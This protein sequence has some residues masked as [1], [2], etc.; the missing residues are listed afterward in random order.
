MI[1]VQRLCVAAATGWS[2]R[3]E[4][5]SGTARACVD[6]DCLKSWRMTADTRRRWLVRLGKIA[7]VLLVL[8]MLLRWFEYKQTYHPSRSF[9]VGAAE[10]GRAWED[11]HFTAA[12]GVKLHGWFFPANTNST[13][14]H[15][16]VILC[17]GNGGNISHRLGLYDALLA[18][19]VSV[20]TFDYRGYGRS[21]GRPGEEGTYL[22]AQ[23]A[24][25]WM[26]QKGFTPTNLVVF[27]ESLGGG[28][29]SELVLRE[30]CGG[31]VLQNTFTSLPDIGSELYPFL[32][33]RTLGRIRYDTHRRLPRI[34]VPVLVMHSRSDSLIPFHH[35][36]RNFAAANEPKFLCE[37]AGDHNDGVVDREKFIAGMEQLWRRLD[38]HP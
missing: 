33:V 2:I 19:G 29:A 3:F 13:R 10:L 4:E 14:A 15:L 36:E 16:A 37:T 11:V 17:H 23:A 27:G 8:F 7:L 21:E 28:I 18:G 24:H 22:D 31:L 9:H 12:D 34:H 5:E 26:K 30:P 35:A 38:V 20:F 6:N 1:W 25:A 32:P